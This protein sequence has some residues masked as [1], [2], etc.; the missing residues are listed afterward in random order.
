MQGVDE[1][2]RPVFQEQLDLLKRDTQELERGNLFQAF[3]VFKR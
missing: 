2:Q 3:Q 1:R